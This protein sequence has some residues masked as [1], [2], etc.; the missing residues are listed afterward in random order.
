MQGSFGPLPSVLC[1]LVLISLFPDYFNKGKASTMQSE[2]AL[3]SYLEIATKKASSGEDRDMQ[4][5]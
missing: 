2:C 5:F 1:V 4:D 3:L